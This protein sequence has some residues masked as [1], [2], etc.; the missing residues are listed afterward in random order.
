MRVPRRWLAPLLFLYAGTLCAQQ[1]RDP[2]TAFF[3][4]SLGDFRE[5][6]DIAREEGKSGLLLF[7]EM[8]ECPSVRA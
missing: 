6:L 2:A 1:L 3:D 5:E 4:Q 7:F 8:D